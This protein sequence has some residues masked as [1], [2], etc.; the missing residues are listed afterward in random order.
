MAA[1]KGMN[2]PVL[3]PEPGLA[4][5]G[6]DRSQNPSVR[7][8]DS[9]TGLRPEWSHMLRW[10]DEG[11]NETF[12]DAD[13]QRLRSLDVSERDMKD[14]VCRLCFESFSPAFNAAF[15]GHLDCLEQLHSEGK[16]VDARDVNGATP[17]HA[18]A[19]ACQRACIDF[20][21]ERTGADL[22]ARD[23]IGNTPAHHAAF[24]G[25]LSVL[26]YLFERTLGACVDDCAVDG[27]TPTH[28]A[29]ARGHIECLQ[30]LCSERVGA[31]PT[32]VDCNGSQ[33][34]YFAAQEGQTAAVEWFLTH[35]RADPLH[36][37]LDGM[38]PLHAAA[39]SGRVGCLALLL[40][41]VQKRI[42]TVK[43]NDGATCM[44]FAAAQG[45]GD[46]LRLLLGQAGVT[47]EERD[48]QGATPAHDAAENGQAAC[49]RI[50]MSHG[51]DVTLK[52]REGNTPVML[53][54]QHSHEHC[55]AILQGRAV[56]GNEESEL[57]EDLEALVTGASSTHEPPKLLSLFDLP[58]ALMPP[59]SRDASRRDLGE[60]DLQRQPSLARASS[61][62]RTPKNLLAQKLDGDS[63]SPKTKSRKVWRL[64]Q[65]KKD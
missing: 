17:L 19:E 21:V 16:V 7:V 42:C 11:G 23:N 29:A 64:F 15:L 37:S 46:C 60:G 54:Q 62:R 2:G 38:T 18:A 14:G 41:H 24:H 4:G 22:E 48:N 26:K 12:G 35:T 50:L 6:W 51:A 39:Q 57:L 33:P 30:W 61:R 44:H 34:L 40:R 32:E 65:K 1:A 59:I 52:D 25:Q 36:P 56:A 43:D 63:D 3:P 5:F 31:S 45:H 13:Y 20:L 49:L 58:Q 53:A 28:Y 9:D 8:E 55:V 10:S 27:A 47:G